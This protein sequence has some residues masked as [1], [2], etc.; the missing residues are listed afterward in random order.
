MPP[1]KRPIELEFSLPDQPPHLSHLDEIDWQRCA[2]VLRCMAN[3]GLGLRTEL[4]HAV[5]G[6]MGNPPHSTVVKSTFYNLV[7]AGLV[8]SELAPLIGASRVTLVRLSDDAIDYCN[9]VGWPPVE[10][11]WDALI[12]RRNADAYPQYAAWVLQFAYHARMRHWDVEVASDDDGKKNQ[13]D[14]LLRG[15]GITPVH[16]VGTAKLPL[17]ALET[18]GREYPQINMVVSRPQQLDHFRSMFRLGEFSGRLTDLESLIYQA[19]DG[20]VGCLWMETR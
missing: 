14:L 16:V 19:R 12:E 10:N 4:A 20:N 7:D 8:I 15:G 2:I 17:G 18:L 13:A 3:T 9:S 6:E 5:S 11:E 1:Q